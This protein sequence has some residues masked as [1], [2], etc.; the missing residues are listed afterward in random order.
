MASIAARKPQHCANNSLY[1]KPNCRAAQPAA[2]G[3][4]WI[5]RDR[6]DQDLEPDRAASSVAAGPPSLQHDLVQPDRVV[7]CINPN[8]ATR[9][10]PG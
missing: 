8:P 5:E 10:G 4:V 7:G 1:F 2:P 6:R 9:L 3:A